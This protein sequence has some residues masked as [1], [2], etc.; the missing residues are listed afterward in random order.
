MNC[1]RGA[2]TGGGQTGR[3]PEAGTGVGE[4]CRNMGAEL[5]LNYELAACTRKLDL[6]WL[7]SAD[8]AS[9]AA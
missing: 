4:I 2:G 1:C 8:P 9:A 6:E 5:S 3:L 7:L